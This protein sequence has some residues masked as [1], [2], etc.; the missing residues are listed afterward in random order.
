MRAKECMCDT[1]EGERELGEL[2]NVSVVN[3]ARRAVCPTLALL[4][5]PF[6]FWMKRFASCDSISWGNAA[7]L[8]GAN[9]IKLFFFY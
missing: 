7:S 4:C 6:F 9:L 1:Q 5:N 8:G 2:R 3:V